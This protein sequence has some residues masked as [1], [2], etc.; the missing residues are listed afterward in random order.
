MI[1]PSNR[2][3]IVVAT[4]PVGFKGH[5]GLVAHVKNA[6]RRDTISLRN[7]EGLADDVP[8][9]FVGTRKGKKHADPDDAGGVAGWGGHRGRDQPAARA[10]PALLRGSSA[11]YDKRV[12][13]AD[14]H[15]P[16]MRWGGA[17]KLQHFALN[18]LGH[19]AAFRSTCT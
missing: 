9:V 19:S 8:R 1:F 12:A 18:A 15:G 13:L 4:K 2:V 3:W 5:D 7:G 11:G 6:L 16:L 10:A 14:R 17:G